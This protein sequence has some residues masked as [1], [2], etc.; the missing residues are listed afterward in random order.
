MSYEV[1][2]RE[3]WRYS[4]YAVSNNK[5]IIV[6][7]LEYEPPDKAKASETLSKFIR[8]IKFK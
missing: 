3:I 7:Q 8:G 4:F 2:D 6:D 1:K 5:K